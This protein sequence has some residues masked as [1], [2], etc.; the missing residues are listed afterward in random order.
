MKTYFIDFVAVGTAASGAAALATHGHEMLNVIRIPKYLSPPL[1]FG[2]SFG[3]SAGCNSEA[4]LAELAKT[5][6]AKVPFEKASKEA[7]KSWCS[8]ATPVQPK[9]REY[10]AEFLIKNRRTKK[11]ALA[12]NFHH[13]KM[14]PTTN[15]RSNLH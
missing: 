1:A 8:T 6:P 14:A 4:I 11:S 12:T 2:S 15:I 3:V 10:P 13:Q 7:K 5:T 9:Y